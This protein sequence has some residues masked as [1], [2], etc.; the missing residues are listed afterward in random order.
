MT[1]LLPSLFVSHGAPTFALEPGPAGCALHAL[2]ALLPR[3]RAVLVLSP[4]WITAGLEIGTNPQPPTIHDFGGFP[5]ALYRLRYPAAGAPH[6]AQEVMAQLTRAGLAARANPDRGLDHGTWTPL[7][8]LYPDADVPV[9]PLSLPLTD[10]P[11]VVHALGQAL[12]GLSESGVLF[13]ASGAITHNLHDVRPGRAQGSGYAPRFMD[14][15]ASTIAAGDLPALLDYRRRAPDAARAHPTPEH[16]LPLFAAIGAAGDAW[17]PAFR[18]PGGL[19]Y[20]V[21]GMDAYAFGVDQAL[22]PTFQTATASTWESMSPM[23]G[24]R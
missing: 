20:G 24:T 23:S 4:H 13:L 9:V 19:T 7:L 2:G 10:S 6:V 3:P 15:M 1:T 22:R 11:E 21:I 16:L 8:H 17:Q 14:W 5:D 12:A 18:L